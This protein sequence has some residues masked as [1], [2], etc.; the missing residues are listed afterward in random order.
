MCIYLFVFVKLK[1]WLALDNRGGRCRDEPVTRPVTRT[2]GQRQVFNYC[3]AVIVLL[4]LHLSLCYSQ[5]QN[6]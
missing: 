1:Q 6:W 3:S 5:Q 4:L 2:E